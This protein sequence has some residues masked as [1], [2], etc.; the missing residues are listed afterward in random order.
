M[1]KKPL[2]T[3]QLVT[4]GHALKQQIATLKSEL[5]QLEAQLIERGPGVHAAEDAG[6]SCTVVIPNA[7]IKPT[8]EDIEACRAIAG[9]HFGKLF[10]SSTTYS[11]VKGFREVAGALLTKPK[12]TKLLAQVEKAAKAFV[13]WSK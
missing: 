12:L 7:G 8:K 9:T 2:T 10:A 13:T 4:K 6:V 5:E 1:A 11:P 3:E